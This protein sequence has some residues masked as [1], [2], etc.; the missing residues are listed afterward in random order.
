MIALSLLFSIHGLLKGAVFFTVFTEAEIPIEEDEEEDDED[1]DDD[2]EDDE[3]EEDED[4]PVDLICDVGSDS[5]LSVSSS[6]V[7]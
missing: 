6:S 5:L 7:S 3:D 2:D 4:D 1:E